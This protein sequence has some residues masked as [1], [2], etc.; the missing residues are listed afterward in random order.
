MDRL[1]RAT[2]EREHQ[3]KARGGPVPAAVVGP[4]AEFFSAATLLDMGGYTVSHAGRESSEPFSR[5]LFHVASDGKIVAELSHDYRGEEHW[6][7]RPGDRW[8]ALPERVI[9]GGGPAPLTLTS[10][11]V[12]A[13]EQLLA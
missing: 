4:V 11:G 6:I 10:A 7:R 2:H 1:V 12:R 13:V 5:Y 8:A 9:Q 3:Q